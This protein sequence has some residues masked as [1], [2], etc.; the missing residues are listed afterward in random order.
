MT[1]TIINLSNIIDSINEHIGKAVSWLTLFMVLIMFAI[2]LM[3]YAFNEGSIAIQE[4][5]MY[6][7]A[8]VFMLGAAFTLKRDGHV[9]VDIFYNKMSERKKSIVNFL[10]NLFLLFPVC[11]F[12]LWSSWDYVLEAWRIKESSREAGGLP[13]T[14]ILKTSILCMAILLIL[15]A[16]ADT[17]RN[18]LGIINNPNTKTLDN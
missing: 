13:W 18:V 15:Q 7:H 12:I 1:K 17:L 14:Y 10:G 3:R 6:M 8:V 9:R 2:V 4:S 11:I 5:V 16:L